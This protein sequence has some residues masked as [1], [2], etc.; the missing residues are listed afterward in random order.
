MDVSSIY[1]HKLPAVLRW[2]G[3]DEHADE[4]LALLADE[5]RADGEAEGLLDT[6]ERSLVTAA[7]VALQAGDT[8]LLTGAEMTH[9]AVAHLRR[10]AIGRPVADSEPSIAVVL[11]RGHAARSAALLDMVAAQ[12]GELA[13]RDDL[14]VFVVDDQAF[15]Q[16]VAAGSSDEAV[17]LAHAWLTAHDKQ[18]IEARMLR[19]APLNAGVLEQHRRE[20]GPAL[21]QLRRCAAMGQGGVLGTTSVCLPGWVEAGA[22]AEVEG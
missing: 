17:D 11:S 12:H 14:R 6:L 2:L 13:P 20:F 16:L 15:Y 10:A 18:R 8:D 21:R 3:L 5:A 19:V 9:C 4:L 7:G 22:W 1:E